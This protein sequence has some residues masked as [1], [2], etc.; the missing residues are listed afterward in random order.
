MNNQREQKLV[1]LDLE[2]ERIFRARRRAQQQGLA[3]VEGMAEVACA[4]NA[5]AMADDRDRAIR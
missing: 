4:N 1:P 5:A 2:I 3:G